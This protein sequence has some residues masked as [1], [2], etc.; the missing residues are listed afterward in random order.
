[1]MEVKLKLSR[2]G[3][4]RAE[5]AGAPSIVGPWSAIHRSCAFVVEFTGL[6]DGLRL[7]PRSVGHCVGRSVFND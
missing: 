4:E 3:S 6:V 7:G 1:M 5:A 2:H